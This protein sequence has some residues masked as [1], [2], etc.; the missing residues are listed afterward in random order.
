M[1][2]ISLETPHTP[3]EARSPNLPGSCQF[4]VDRHHQPSHHPCQEKDR[5]H[6]F[7]PTL[8]LWSLKGVPKETFE[9]SFSSLYSQLLLFNNQCLTI[10]PAGTE[11]MLG[12]QSAADSNMVNLKGGLGAWPEVEL[13]MWYQEGL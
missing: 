6:G 5:D 10:V 9:G 2:L 7:L 1:L 12:F 11:I 13:L 4:K 3:S 8:T